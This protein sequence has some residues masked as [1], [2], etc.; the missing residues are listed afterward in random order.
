V[1]REEAS[2]RTVT[3]HLGVISETK[4]LIVNWV[5]HLADL[6]ILLFKSSG[7]SIWSI[8]LINHHAIQTRK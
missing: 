6:G 2:C 1:G 7:F 5:N 4:Y 8:S 3:A